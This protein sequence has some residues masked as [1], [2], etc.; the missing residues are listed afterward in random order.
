MIDTLSGVQ[1]DISQADTPQLFVALDSKLQFITSGRAENETFRC[2]YNE[3]THSL[4]Q[5]FQEIAEREKI[6]I[7]T[8]KDLA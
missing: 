6:L 3:C 4:M 7:E 1:L 8:Y 5:S 2:H